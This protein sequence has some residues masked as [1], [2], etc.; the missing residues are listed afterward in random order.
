MRAVTSSQMISIEERAFKELGLGV[1]HLMERAGK[2]LA[3]EYRRLFPAK[4]KVVVVC[5]K[6]N[7]GGDGFVAARALK[8]VGYGVSVF[9]AF[10][11]DSFTPAARRAFE[12]LP[13]GV[14]ALPFDRKE[15]LAGQ[16]AEA[17]GVIDAL[18]G[19]G[20]RGAVKG[21]AGEVI[22]LINRSAKPVVSADLPSGVNADSG[23]VEG[24]CIKASA[25]VAFTCPK[26]GTL[27]YPGAEFAGRLII[28]DIGIPESLVDEVGDVFIG[29]AGEMRN[30]LPRYDPAQNKWSR[31]S[32]LV[33]AGSLG[34]GGA[35]ILAAL[36]AMR[37]GAGVVGLAVP[38]SIE[39]IASTSAIEAL[40]YPL[41]ETERAS[42][43][44][45]AFDRIVEI[46]ARYRAAV[47]GPGL[48][49]DEETMHLVERLVSEI[50][51]PLVLDGDALSAFSAKIE[52]LAMR[53]APVVITPH[54]GE[55]GRL[56]G[57][58]SAEIEEDRLG[59]A[60]RALRESRATVVLKGART[61][62]AAEEGLTINLT[63]NPGL[64]TAGSGDVLSGVIGALLAQGLAPY[65][66][67]RLGVYLAG[68]AGDI[69][70]ES[71]TQYSITAG[72]NADFLP[73]AFKKL[74]EETRKEG[75]IEAGVR[76]G[77]RA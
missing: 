39:P 66:A 5:G 43:S 59:H 48:S 70:A 21:I 51:R 34:M 71:L 47:I 52:R 9:R 3:E 49:R 35:A 1:D 45:K 18:F 27:L 32:V 73:R 72:D 74:S 13:E 12:R 68:L 67:A 69:A 57:V 58:S 46:L 40:K 23:K 14:P 64:A 65:A 60:R 10:P 75:K 20:L 19:F 53:R 38:A 42:L 24:P 7:N 31:G 8:E 36:G 77:K 50:D 28:A 61:I 17:E 54:S 26:I 22:D 15:E 62:V 55:M 33:V 76:S 2:A 44:M 16:L 30:L 29:E 4:R 37:A 11:A 63:G 25:T 41:P 6:G 56:L